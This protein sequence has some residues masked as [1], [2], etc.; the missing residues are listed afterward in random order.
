[1]KKLA[2]I[3]THPIQYNAPFFKL[4]A[5][6]KN[7]DLKVFYTW[8]QSEVGGK[9]DPGFGQ[10]VNWNIPLLEGYTYSF[11][12]NISKKPGSHHFKG[13]DNPT[14]IWEIKNWGADAVLVYGWAFKSHLK[15]IRF[16]YKKLPVYFRG[17]STLLDEGKG[18]KQ[19]LRR[20]FLQ[21]IYRNID[22]A[23]YAGTANKDY[24]KAMGL[25]EK[26][27]VF[28]PHA[29]DNDRFVSNAEN[30]NEGQHIRKTLNIN[31][32][33]IVFLF[34]GKLEQKKQPDVLIECFVSFHFENNYL[35][36]AGSGQME[37]G[38]KD[39]YKSNPHVIFLGFKNQEQMPA[40]YNA[41]DVFVLPS[42]GPNE[43]WGLSINEAMAAGKAIIASDKCGASCDL[44]I[45]NKN[46]FVIESDNIAS[47]TEA[48]NFF[49]N[50]I[51]AIKIMGDA[52]VVIIQQYSFIQ[53][54]YS[55]E[56]RIDKIVGYI[57]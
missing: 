47:L 54:C 51:T 1:M 52:S 53:D 38:L 12:N 17:D 28:M 5:E 15:A 50:N 19:I 21:Y 36:I 6:R 40:V 20:L 33:A 34:A 49:V 35:I 14:L 44:I 43:T 27:L 55:I 37:K 46:G 32:N 7:V 2:I 31:K 11:V 48:L 23:F 4:L 45:Q 24:F 39:A 9:Y 30:T 26:Q 41:C 42:K 8:S 13:I 16:F 57:N 56:D 25:K 3:T 22:T 29:I 18:F 10:K